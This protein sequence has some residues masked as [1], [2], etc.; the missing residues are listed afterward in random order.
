MAYAVYHH[1]NDTFFGELLTTGENDHLI[2]LQYR[3]K[4]V[5]VGLRMLHFLQKDYAR[6]EKDYNRYAGYDYKYHVDEIARMICITASWNFSFGRDYKGQNKRMN[7]SDSD[8]GV[9]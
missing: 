6:K 4:N 1:N 8:S 5:T 2:Q 9:M 7:N 3:L